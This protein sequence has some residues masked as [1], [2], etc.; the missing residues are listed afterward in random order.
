MGLTWD[1][2]NLAHTYKNLGRKEGKEEG[3]LEG[4]LE[5]QKKF[6]SKYL[7]AQFGDNSKKLEEK[8]MDISDIETLETLSEQ[9]FHAHKIEEAEKIIVEAIEK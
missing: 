2:T 1:K 9:L 5:G 8:I 7:K 3:K 4:R 6:L